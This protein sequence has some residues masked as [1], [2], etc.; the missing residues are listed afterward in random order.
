MPSLYPTTTPRRSASRP[1]GSL[2]RLPMNRLPAANDNVA[3]RSAANDNSRFARR[4]GY[5]G[6]RFVLKKVLPR[7]IPFL[8]AAMTAYEL[9]QLAVWDNPAVINTGYDLSAWTQ[10]GTY[11]GGGEEGYSSRGLERTCGLA[12]HTLKTT[13][14]AAEGN[15]KY[16]GPYGAPLKYDVSFSIFKGKVDPDPIF[17]PTYVQWLYHSRYTRTILASDYPLP[18]LSSAV[19]PL[20]LDVPFKVGLAVGINPDL[21]PILNPGVFPETLPYDLLPAMDALP[22]PFRESSQ[23]GARP[24]SANVEHPWVSQ[25]PPVNALPNYLPQVV[26]TNEPVP[27]PLAEQFHVLRPPGSRE[28][29]AKVRALKVWRGVSTIFNPLTEARDVVDILYY[30]LPV[31]FRPRYKNTSYERLDVSY[32]EKMLTIY[33]NFE[34]I[35]MSKAMRGLLQNEL[36]DAIYAFAGSIGAKNSAL[37]KKPVGGGINTILGNMP[38]F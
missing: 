32:D 19:F 22:V 31:K 9:Y 1:S 3:L 24:W 20:P 8:N 28:K 26:Y 23:P 18:A 37:L 16:V 38:R 34:S 12:G 15:F 36:E 2:S 25:N 21:Q 13:W 35:D 29:E 7:A 27:Q 30:S 6:A 33:K 11:C 14:D 4:V 17:G 10:V 5:A